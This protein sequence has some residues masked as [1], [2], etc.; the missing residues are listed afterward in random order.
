MENHALKTSQEVEKPRGLKILQ[1]IYVLTGIV[2]IV[3]GFV[4][5]GMG[6]GYAPGTPSYW[7]LMYS[8]ILLLLVPL[9][10][11]V[12]AYA[13]FFL[14]STKSRIIRI[15]AFAIILSWILFLPIAPRIWP[16]EGLGCVGLGLIW[17]WATPHAIASILY[18]VVTR[19]LKKK[20]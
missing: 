15:F 16:C 18:L 1:W 3:L 8:S 11:F 13:S 20:S 4:A 5:L 17:I 12:L 9:P 14:S 2:Y 19:N 6:K 10:F 7:P